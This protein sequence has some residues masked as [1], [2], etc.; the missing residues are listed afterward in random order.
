MPAMPA[1]TST[2]GCAQLRREA[3]KVGWQRQAAAYRALRVFLLPAPVLARRG[4]NIAPPA[5]LLFGSPH[6]YP[7]EHV[8]P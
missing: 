7:L 4:Q 8:Y 5:G 3:P 1:A 2:A 6:R